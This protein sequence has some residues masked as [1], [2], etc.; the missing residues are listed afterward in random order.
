MFNSVFGKTME[1]VETI[2]HLRLTTDPNMAIKQFSML[3]FKTEKYLEGLYMFEKYKTTV[4]MSR[5]MYVGCAMLDL[6]K[7]TALEFHY[8]G[9]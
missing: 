4:V 6:S 1:N 8:N 5:P 2:I 7:M 9:I 3:N